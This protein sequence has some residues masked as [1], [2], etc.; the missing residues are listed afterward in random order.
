[1]GP[2]PFIPHA[3]ARMCTGLLSLHASNDTHSIQCA[4]KVT[5]ICPTALGEGNVCSRP[6]DRRFTRMR[7]GRRC[8]VSLRHG[9][10]LASSHRHMPLG[11]HRGGPRVWTFFFLSEAPNCQDH[12]SD[13]WFF[14]KSPSSVQRSLALLLFLFSPI[15]PLVLASY[16]AEPFVSILTP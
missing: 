12:A 15:S 7:C 8:A 9:A 10:A 4:P 13:C 5:A 2:L 1:M 16:V 3:H 14:R 6:D 11:H